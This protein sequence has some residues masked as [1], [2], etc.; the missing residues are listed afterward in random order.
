MKSK[1]ILTQKGKKKVLRGFSRS[2]DFR[3]SIR[4]CFEKEKN[5]HPDYTFTR[6]CR[7]VADKYDITPERVYQII[8]KDFEYEPWKQ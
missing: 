7:L 3:I 5:K 4:Q 6:V 2:I 8:R 1:E